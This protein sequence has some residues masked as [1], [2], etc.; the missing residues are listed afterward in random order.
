MQQQ[1]YGPI[2]YLG[3]HLAPTGLLSSGPTDD[4]L[5]SL[6]G[7]LFSTAGVASR[8]SSWPASLQDLSEMKGGLVDLAATPLE[9]SEEQ[10]ASVSV[11][12]TEFPAF[13]LSSIRELLTVSFADF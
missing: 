13:S 11:L 1:P 5:S 8:A 3:S 6:D 10:S 12:A 2:D 9:S 4:S 7:E